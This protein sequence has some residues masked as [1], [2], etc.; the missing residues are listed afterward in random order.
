MNDIVWL[1]MRRMRRPLILL[2]LIYFL[3]VMVLVLLPG[4]D[5]QGQPFY[6][7]FLDASYFI[8]ILSTT[9]GLG[10][11][12]FPFTDAQRLVVFLIIFPNVVAW[13]YAIGTILG[14]FLDPDFK[15]VLRRS[16]FTRQV[17]WL[18][19]PFYLVC[20][21]GNTGSLVVRGLLRRGL[22]AV[23]LERDAD[24]VNRMTLDDA[25]SHI[26]ALACETTDRRNLELG[27]IAHPNCQGVIVTTNEDHANLTIAITVKL[28][29][30]GLPVYARSESERVGDNMVSFGTDYVVNPYAIF[31][32][33][34]FLALSSPIK[35]LVQDWLISVPGTRLR[36]LLKPPRGRYIVCGAG[37]FGSR[38]IE[39]LDGSGVEYTVVEVHPE[40][41]EKYPGGVLGRGTEAE[42]LEAAGIMDAAGIIAGTGDDIDNLSIVMTALALNSRLFVVARQEK[43]VNGAL[44]DA[45]NA[46]LVAKRSLI[47][48]RRMLAVATTPLLQAFLQHLV[49]QP[50]AFAERVA[51]ALEDILE[52]RSPSLWVADLSGLQSEGIKAAC[53]S[54]IAL[55]LG[56]LT[57]NARSA[58][59]E[60]LACLCLVLERGAQRIFMPESDMTL[61]EGDRLLFAGRGNARREMDRALADPVLLMDAATVNPL[62]RTAIWRWLA[63]RR[64]AAPDAKTES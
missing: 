39:Q 31:A 64:S 38:M 28:L 56:H 11:L 29:R 49:A 63:S 26:P 52:G 14:L 10:E 42:T 30:P 6:M 41:L 45:S 1:T 23:V 51:G 15:A 61:L 27:G 58:D 50:D 21:F 2:I 16:Q 19:E 13:L 44:F 53:E 43:Q 48:A 60:Q 33:R 8:V 12:P 35:Y 36:R 17:R 54:G 18:G 25:Y 40:R 62:P 5:D 37:R 57:R 32:E 46:D 34:L 9:I 55:D 7:S 22:Q 47:V 20:G 24:K 3:S 59:A 4:M